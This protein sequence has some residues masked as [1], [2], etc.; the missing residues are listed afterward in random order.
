M[1]RDDP[2]SGCP[3]LVKSFIDGE[4]REC[5][6]TI[7]GTIPLCYVHLMAL[8]PILFNMRYSLPYPVRFWEEDLEGR[9]E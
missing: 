3:V 5:G 6:G 9:R 7:E 8:S 4:E 2:V 1:S